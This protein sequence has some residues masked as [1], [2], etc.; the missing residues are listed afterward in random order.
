[1]RR[2][3]LLFF[4]SIFLASF[5]APIRAQAPREAD[6]FI[7]FQF[8]L[9]QY[10]RQPENR[11]KKGWKSLKRW[12]DFESR[13]MN[14][15]GGSA[16]PRIWSDALVQAMQDKSKP[17]TARMGGSGWAPYGP[18]DYATPYMGYAWIPGIG[19]INCITFHPTNGQ[20]FWVGV[21]QG[22]VWKTMDGGLSWMPL[23]DDLPT[24]RVSD[25]AVN[26][27]NPNEM[28]VC[29]GDYAYLGAGLSLDDRKRHTHYGL[30][31]FK[32]NDG[33]ATWIPSGLSFAQ[34]DFDFSLLRRCFVNPGNGQELVAAGT[35][36]VYRSTDAG[37]TWTQTANFFAWDLEK[38]PTNPSVL[39]ASSGYR[40]SL[41]Y[42]QAGIWKSTDFGAT[43]TALNTGIPTQGVIQR[44]ELAI[45]PSDP[46]KLYALCAGMDAGF[47]GLYHSLDGGANWTLQSTTPNI[48]EWYDGNGSGGQGWYDLA[49]IVNPTNPDVIYTGGINV[50]ASTDA[51]ANWQG[52]SYW[53]ADFGPAPHADQHQLAYNPVSGKYY[54][55]NDGGLYETS[56][57]VPGSWNDANSTPGYQWPTQWTPLSSGMQVTSFYRVGVSQGNPGNVVAGAQ[58][59]ATYFFNGSDW[60]NIIGGDGMDCF[61]DPVDPDVIYGS[62]QYG[63]LAMS[64]DGGF[65]SFGVANMPD[66]GEWV[67]PWQ[68]DPTDRN[69]VYAAMRELWKSTD[70]GSTWTP[71]SSFPV[72]P[73]LGV[74]NVSSAFAV[75]PSNSDFLYLSKRYFKSIGEPSAFWS[76]SNGGAT[77]TQRSLGVPDS[78]Y[79]TMIAVDADDPLTVYV[80]LGGFVPGQKVL[81]STDGGATWQNISGS[82]PNLPVNCI[83]HHAG[84][85][86]NPIYVGTDAGVYYRNDTMT[87]WMAFSNLLPNVIV[88]DLDIHSST[89]K[90]YAATFGRGIWVADVQDLGVVG[91]NE[92]LRDMS[93]QVYPNPSE[94]SPRIRIEASG[95]NDVQFEL[96]DILG[97]VKGAW[98]DVL[99]NGLCDIKCP[100]PLEPGVYYLKVGKGGLGKVVRFVVQ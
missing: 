50:W 53:V 98:E 65:S 62:Y 20:I 21:A 99:Q 67:T 8:Q 58:D 81:K 49:L 86:N 31:I 85:P 14:P 4:A 26:P 96:V 69:T 11:Q 23:T 6:A 45:A 75:A 3:S 74:P 93:V 80:T 5:L 64:N 89:Q 34:T 7:D 70:M 17:Q 1:M 87:Y 100:L 41:N 77:W 88:S 54:L 91:V 73:T 38:H 92:G 71:I 97:R 35:E 13:R 60:K 47:G 76:S 61:L 56:A 84:V 55:C 90:I 16:D 46:S 32:T 68:L 66:D 25:I 19:R 15:D 63:G 22:G 40:A 12:E 78:L 82:L 57:I 18:N 42:G 59:N 72:N 83:I 33:G 44:I 27:S 10:L 48:L 36:G 37:V 29:S 28:Y 51:G 79:H 9:H 30:G 39:Y 43:W 94:D 24:L 52:C 2:F 95:M